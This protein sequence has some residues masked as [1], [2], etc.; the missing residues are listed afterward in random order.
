MRAMDSNQ[1][2]TVTVAEQQSWLARQ[3]YNQ[4]QKS[5]VLSQSVYS[6]QG[7]QPSQG[8]TTVT[9]QQSVSFQSQPLAPAVSSP[10]TQQN[11]QRQIARDSPPPKPSGPNPAVSGS[12]AARE[13][14]P[15]L[16]APATDL[17]TDPLAAAGIVFDHSIDYTVGPN[18]PAY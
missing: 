10:P 1:D 17:A 18:L 5:P 11:V 7:Q 16:S 8:F 9:G 4:S 12:P 2:G 14:Q 15:S 3:A 13:G 6:I